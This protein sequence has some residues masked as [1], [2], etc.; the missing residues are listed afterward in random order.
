MRYRDPSND[1]GS[2]V[3]EA[4]MSEVYA[5]RPKIYV[6]FARWKIPRPDREDLFQGVAIVTWMALCEDRVR[7]PATRPPEE[8]LYGFMFET[9]RHLWQNYRRLFRHSE[10]PLPEAEFASEH[11]VVRQLEARDLLR[12]LAALPHVAELLLLAALRLGLDE[13]I[14][15]SGMRRALYFERLIEA[16]RWL[17]AI[18]RSGRWRDPPW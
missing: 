10:V 1:D 4:T 15:A 5:L 7:G 14:A 3:V 12:R 13:R 6:R 9:A 17:R 8:S 11:V 2:S 18:A 16:R